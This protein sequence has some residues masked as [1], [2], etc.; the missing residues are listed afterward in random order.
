MT[1]FQSYLIVAP[2]RDIARQETKKLAKSL[3]IDIEKASPDV[4]FI[5]PPKDQILIDQVRDLKSH[6]FEKPFKEKYKFVVIEN[7]DTAAAEAQNS[8]LKILEEP[9]EHAIIVLLAKNKTQLLPTIL[10]RIILME[11]ENVIAIPS[12]S[13]EEQS[14][15][16]LDQDLASALLDV[17][18]CKNPQEFLDRQI[19]SLTALLIKSAKKKQALS[20]SEKKIARTIEKCKEAKE[21]IMANVNPTFTLTNLIFGVHLAS[22]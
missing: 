15:N 12:L 17:N 3:G 16:L 20:S 9:P 7:A 8:L 5:T 18:T 13:R 4:F 19:I 10:S 22:K 6:I 11:P 1:N 2:S 14:K 21:M